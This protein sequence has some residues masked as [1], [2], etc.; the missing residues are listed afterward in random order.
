MIT[1]F[2]QDI[3][4]TASEG[5]TLRYFNKY[6]IIIKYVILKNTYYIYKI[7]SHSGLFCTCLFVM[8]NRVLHF[9]KCEL[10]VQNISSII[11]YS[12]LF[13]I[14]INS[15]FDDKAEIY[16]WLN[17]KWMFLMISCIY[18]QSCWAF[19]VLP[20]IVCFNDVLQMTV[21]FIHELDEICII[22]IIRF[23]MPI[24]LQWHRAL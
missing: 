16:K 4:V 23:V 9:T 6:I 13:F 22:S 3:P 1:Q 2:S 11:R 19:S 17:Y 15:T 5:M 24:R 21:T 14:Q 18:R 7:Y 10:G 8:I 12:S 20:C